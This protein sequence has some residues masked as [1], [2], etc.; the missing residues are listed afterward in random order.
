M[1]INQKCLFVVSGNVGAYGPPTRIIL[2]VRL[3][4]RTSPPW[5]VLISA[6][7]GGVDGLS[8]SFLGVS[9]T[10]SSLELEMV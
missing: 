2:N 8:W 10:R 4:P 6:L 3:E 1:R 7:T 9:W 5:H